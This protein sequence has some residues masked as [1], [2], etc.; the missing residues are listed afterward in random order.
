MLALGRM[1]AAI[2]P[3][4]PAFY[5]HPASVE[6]IVAHIV[7]RILDQVGLTVDTAGRWQGMG[8]CGPC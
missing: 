7:D 1:G 5:D 3:P 4:M 6:D 8:T 2:V